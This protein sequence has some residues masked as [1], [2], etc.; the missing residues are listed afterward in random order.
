MSISLDLVLEK[1]DV[2]DPGPGVREVTVEQ[3]VELP[4]TQLAAG[5]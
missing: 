1:A 5:G 4:A 3:T 2:D